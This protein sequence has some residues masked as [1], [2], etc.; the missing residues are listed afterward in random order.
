[1][2][3]EKKITINLEPK[4]VDQN[5]WI[6]QCKVIFNRRPIKFNADLEFKSSK[7]SYPTM[8]KEIASNEF[9]QY[10]Y[11]TLLTMLIRFESKNA[12]DEY[13]M[14]GITNRL[15][16]YFVGILDR[17]NEWVFN[18]LLWNLEDILTYKKYKYIESRMFNKNSTIADRY[19]DFLYAIHHIENHYNVKLRSLINDS[20]FDMFVLGIYFS[21]FDYLRAKELY[22][23][24][25]FKIFSNSAESTENLG[26]YKIIEWFYERELRDKFRQ[27][28]ESVS[29]NKLPSD[30]KNNIAV[31]SVLEN[32]QVTDEIL[33]KSEKIMSEMLVI[34]TPLEDLS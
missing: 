28:I 29:K 26:A 6:V 8:S 1:M 20:A 9:L 19:L 2:P 7:D 15:S 33:A 34:G 25:G 22:S 24:S 21:L 13:K 17:V 14:K 18:I 12:D 27:F 5:K 3:R 10:H 31:S 30:F 11:K 4:E 23:L 32:Y 16:S